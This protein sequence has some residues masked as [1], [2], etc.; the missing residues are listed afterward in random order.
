MEQPSSPGTNPVEMKECMEELVKFTLE[1]YINQT[2]QLDLA[3][4]KDFCSFLL[5][6]VP[7]TSDS[8]DKGSQYPL[9]KHLALA[10]Y[11]SVTC[12][13]A[14]RGAC[15]GI[16]DSD[17]KKRE[18]WNE[19]VL[20][21]GSE[22]VEACILVV[23]LSFPTLLLLHRYDQEICYNRIEFGVSSA[24]E[25][26][27]LRTSCSRT[28]FYPIE[29]DLKLFVDG[30]KTV[31]GRCAVG[32]YNRIGPGALILFNK[33]LVLEV[34]DVNWYRSF[35]EMFQAQSLAKVLPSV[36]STNEGIQVYRKFYT[37]EKEKSNGVLA[38][39]V[40]KWPVQPFFHMARILSGLSYEGLQ[41]L[42]SLYDRTS[43][44]ADSLLQA[45]LRSEPT[46]TM[47]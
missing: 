1:S 37:E 23:I 7:L 6:H 5:Q 35:Y 15:S 24:F 19:L 20:K 25:D 8:C 12:A 27:K 17:L 36:K 13:A 18:E 47:M 26:Y 9:Y 33:C 3:L 39:C 43:K 31:E 11:E 45:R 32:D 34:Q 41:S 44:V 42:L 2:L 4:S 30:L 40:A 38:I 16:E 28:L 22:L 29:S 21:E 10:L 14:S 46:V